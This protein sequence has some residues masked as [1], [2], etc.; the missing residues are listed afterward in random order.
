MA[1]R[2]W[3][4]DYSSTAVAR[5]FDG[6]GRVAMARRL[7]FGGCGLVAV[8][9]RLW[10]GAHRSAFAQLLWLDSCGV[11]AIS[12]RL[13]LGGYGSVAVVLAN[14]GPVFFSQ[15]QGPYPLQVLGILG[16]LVDVAS[17]LCCRC[18]ISIDDLEQLTIDRKYSL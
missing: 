11:A 1:W 12:R 17:G 2:S 4:S 3:L 9:Q 15:R 13:K 5:W 16:K 10:L 18:A 7:W 6:N 8:A 14:H